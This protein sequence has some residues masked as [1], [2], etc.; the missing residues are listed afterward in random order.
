MQGGLLRICPPR[1]CEVINKILLIAE[2]IRKKINL[3]KIQ[4]FSGIDPWFL[5]QIKQIVE[6][7]GKI[8]IYKKLT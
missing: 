2:A 5:E 3:K 6:E 8:K 1:I 7:E 4:R